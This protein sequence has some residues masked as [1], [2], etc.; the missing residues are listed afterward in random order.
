ME[1]WAAVTGCHSLAV[2]TVDVTVCFSRQTVM[3]S[4]R[5]SRAHSASAA[6]NVALGIFLRVSGKSP[7]WATLSL[8]LSVITALARTLACPSATSTIA[9]TLASLVSSSKQ[10]E[11]RRVEGLEEVDNFITRQPPKGGE[12]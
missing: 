10:G 2:C 4:P 9:C 5:A 7:S 8:S 11:G 3:L 6:P 1:W 12:R